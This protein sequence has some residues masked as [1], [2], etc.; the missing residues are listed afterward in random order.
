MGPSYFIRNGDC[1]RRVT[2]IS[3]TSGDAEGGLEAYTQYIAYFV[4]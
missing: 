3:I 1:G 4:L 2:N